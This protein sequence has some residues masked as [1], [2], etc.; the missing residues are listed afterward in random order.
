MSRQGERWFERN[1]FDKNQDLVEKIL[2]R[3]NVKNYH[4]VNDS[5]GN[6]ALIITKN[7][8]KYR[9]EIYQKEYYDKD[10]ERNET[11][12]YMIIKRCEVHRNGQKHSKEYMVE[13][14]RIYED[15][16]WCS[17]RWI[18]KNSKLC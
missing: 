11:E 18:A 3:F 8:K 17:I 16:L 9:L 13:K 1:S 4:F 12:S 15:C 6:L 14:K 2:N 10:F 5:Y 7:L